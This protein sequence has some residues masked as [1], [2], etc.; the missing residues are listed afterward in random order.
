MKARLLEK[1]RNDVIPAMQKEFGRTNIHSLPR[2]EKICLNMGIGKAIED[3]KIL[4]EGVKV[5]TT[6]AGQAA[7]VTKARVSVSNFKLRQGYKIGC[8]VTLRGQTM[9]E[10]FDRLVSTAIPRIRDFRGV[11]KKSFDKSG[12]YSIGVEE[13]TIFPEVDADRLV[14]PFGMDVTFVIKNSKGPDESRAFLKMMGMP[15]AE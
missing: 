1:Y 4:E 7:V 15:F 12:N 11:S 2:I 6:I 14:H 5:M 10:F 9:Y 13:V 3:A 8:R